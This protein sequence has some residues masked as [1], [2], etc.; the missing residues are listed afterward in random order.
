MIKFPSIIGSHCHQSEK[1][2]SPESAVSIWRCGHCKWVFGYH[3]L[4][5]IQ[6]NDNCFC[7]NYLGH[8]HGISSL[9]NHCYCCFHYFL[10]FCFILWRFWSSLVSQVATVCNKRKK[11]YGKHTLLMPSGNAQAKC[12]FTLV[13]ARTSVDKYGLVC[14]WWCV[15]PRLGRQLNFRWISYSLEL[16][17]IGVPNVS[18]AHEVS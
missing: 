9:R 12:I 11:I 17:R 15:C 18:M 5:T 2:V 4:G 13:W 3:R 1:R 10:C 8:N 16:E 14:Q 7:R 6:G